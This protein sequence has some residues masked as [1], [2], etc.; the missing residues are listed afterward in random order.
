MAPSAGMS[1]TPRPF[2]SSPRKPAFFWLT[3]FLAVAF[4]LMYLSMGWIIYRDTPDTESSG[5][6]ASWR[7][8][9]W[10]VTRVDPHGHA[11]GKLELGDRVRAFNG[12]ARAATV[13]PKIYE[14]FLA[15]GPSYTLRVARGS[16]EREV[17]LSWPTAHRPRTVS[18]ILGYLVV[19]I[20]FFGVAIV[21]GLFRPEDRVTQLGCLACL[22]VALRLVPLVLWPYE[23]AGR[24]ENAWIDA[25]DFQDPWHLALGYH[26]Y[27]CFCSNLLR[28]KIWSAI[29]IFLYAVAG[30]FFLFN[31]PIQ[32]FYTLGRERILRFA[33]E[34][35]AFTHF[36]NG[37]FRAGYRDFIEFF[38]LLA[39]CAAIAFSYVRVRDPDQRRRLRWVAFGS[40]AGLSPLLLYDSTLEI[41]KLMGWGNLRASWPVGIDI[42]NL[43]LVAIPFATGYAVVKHRA[44]GVSVVFRQSMKYL[45]ARNVLRGI[46]VLPV[47]GLILPLVRNP[48]RTIA[49]LFLQHSMYLNLL[50]LALLGL[51]L[52]YRVQVRNWVDRKFFREAYD[53][54]KILRELIG[55]IKELDSISE[56]SRLV[57]QQ[58]E[59]A[60]HP[61]CLRVFYR[62]KEKSDLT[63]GY[64]S[65]SGSSQMR[66]PEASQILH[67][68]EQRRRPMDFP[69]LANLGLPGPERDW[70]AQLETQLIVPITGG[71]QRLV[72]V[73]LLGE[74]RS[75]E[76]YTRTD[77]N[78]L[79]G[80]AAQMGVVYERAWLQEQVGEEQRIRRDVLA[81][82]DQTDINL[83]KE[84]P[85]CGACFDTGMRVCAEDGAELTMTLPVERTIDRK[86]RLEK[87][88]GR[89]GMGAV[90]EGTDLRLNRKIAIKI[91]IGSLFGNR[92]AL[93]R[94]EREAKAAAMLN[95]I[96]IVAIH[97]FGM[98]GQDGAYLVMERVYGSSWREELEHR[99][100]LLPATAADWFGQLLRGLKAAHQAG[101][102]HRDL[103]PENVLVV[104][105]EADRELIKILDFGLA[106]MRLFE[107]GQTQSVTLAGGILGTLGYMSPEQLSGAES[108]E[109]SDIFSVGVMAFEAVTGRRPFEGRSYAEVL[110]AMSRSP[111]HLP[112]GGPEV[113]EL[114]RIIAG[115]LASDPVK[116]FGTVSEMETLLVSAL[117]A[118][119]AIAA[120]RSQAG[121]VPTRS[122]GAF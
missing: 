86:Y 101:V 45:L 53:Q 92:A 79:E 5:W 28:E 15:P 18:S 47:I 1:P 81:H 119:P 82:L 117:R 8:G 2:K 106:K 120:D 71:R 115:C 25:A 21:L 94:F 36:H 55:E 13:D 112:G 17:F 39:M 89:G 11:D 90:Y 60:L 30:F 32:L 108:D 122:L 14:H 29:R 54:E 73:L 84:C 49:E 88:I 40:A 33:Y 3:V 12:D 105:Q 114:N 113:A 44:M 38:A 9:E 41:C 75:E 34:H 87:R 46:L 20:S 80:I 22:A 77:R 6:S 31:F 24:I 70:L 107:S 121:H 69:M 63:L 78:L 48:N 97:D 116:R 61:L 57:S 96:N 76:P 67:L 72:G 74:K 66:I 19:S 27:W 10:V 65:G 59:S 110:T 85:R 23:G 50:L 111:V 103:K 52:K 37:L 95:H 4:S 26:F 64:S 42:T 58:V 93:R 98:I 56:I 62:E 83:L 102:A 51:G 104:R 68:L 100:A 109:R 91:L 35:P 7:S 43:C 118:C 99:G 16:V